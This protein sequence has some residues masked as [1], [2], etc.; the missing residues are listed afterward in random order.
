MSVLVAVVAAVAVS[1][2]ACGSSDDEGGEETSAEAW[3]DDVCSSVSSWDS[4]VTQ[5]G[6][7]LRDP[8]D[9]S[10]NEA[11]DAVGDVVDATSTLVTEV[12]DLGP[13]DTEAGEDAQALLETL[14]DDL[15]AEADVL[16]DAMDTDADTAS[17]L[18]ADTSTITGALSTMSADIRTTLEGIEG[19]DG[20]AELQDALAGSE[21]CQQVGVN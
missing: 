5:A 8:R 19:L 13:P 4:A 11:R 15:E 10:V 2:A 9:L 17:E 6:S 18:L 7:T 12:S 16:S 3:A 20:A 1:A 21:S 14:A